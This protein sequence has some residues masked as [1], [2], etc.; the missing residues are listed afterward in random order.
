[1][2]S[3]E[4]IFRNYQVR[5]AESECGGRRARHELLVAGS[6]PVVRSGMHGRRSGQRE[7]HV[8]CYLSNEKSQE[9]LPQL[10]APFARVHR[11]SYSRVFAPVRL[12]A[13]VQ[14]SSPAAKQ[15]PSLR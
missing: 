8:A 15:W 2:L 1:V 6:S 9:K 7:L 11:F 4:S 10:A 5:H 3:V 14:G 13:P 12:F